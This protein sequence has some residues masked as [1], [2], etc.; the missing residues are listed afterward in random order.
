MKKINPI[1]N[2]VFWIR[3]QKYFSSKEDI[4]K[5]G[6]GAS[7]KNDQKFKAINSNCLK[8]NQ[9]QRFGREFGESGKATRD[10]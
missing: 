9:G 6:I 2:L 10:G 8:M 7:E 4:A 3:E 1:C 5:G